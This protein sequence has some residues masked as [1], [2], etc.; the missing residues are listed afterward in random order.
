MPD[1]AMC[2]D[3]ECPSRSQCHRW[4]AWPS[5][6]RQSY[7]CFERSKNADRCA[8]FW[9]ARPGDRTPEEAERDLV[10]M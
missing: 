10:K 4:L 5:A 8:N 6:M 7:G 3:K 9:P 2:A 1:I